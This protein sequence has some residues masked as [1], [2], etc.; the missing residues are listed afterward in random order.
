MY[1]QD[2]VYNE[3]PK[4]R[5]QLLVE[6]ILEL[7]NKIT[8]IESGSGSSSGNSSHGNSSPP[9]LIG[10]PSPAGAVYHIPAPRR[11]S[12]TGNSPRGIN[13]IWNPAPAPVNPAYLHEL[14]SRLRDSLIETFLQNRDRCCL[15]LHVG[16]FIAALSIPPNDHRALHPALVQAVLLIG[17]YFSRS[18]SMT[19][20]EVRFLAQARHDLTLSVT[21]ADRLHDFVRASNLVAFYYFCK[22]NYTEAYQQVSASSN[23]AMSCGLH[24]IHSSVWRPGSGMDDGDQQFL[25]HPVDNTVCFDKVMS[26]VVG[27]PSHLA[28]GPLADPAFRVTTPWPRLIQDY[29]TAAVS[30]QECHSVESLY[31]T[32]L[33]H[34]MA[35]PETLTSLRVQG[36]CLLHYAYHLSHV[37]N[38]VPQDV[39]LLHTAIQYY[40]ARLPGIR[41]AGEMGE[42]PATLGVSPVNQRLV[43]IRTLPLVA[44]LVL[45]QHGG[46]SEARR[47]CGIA[48]QGIVAIIAELAD[49]DYSGLFVG[50]GHIW[51][52][53]C[54]IMINISR[55]AI[56]G[57]REQ[58]NRNLAVV[59]RALKK[60]SIVYPLLG[61]QVQQLELMHAGAA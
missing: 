34:P 41:N 39:H 5:A 7:E 51:N 32:R 19:D 18:P 37:V 4:S 8:Q 46:D 23:M 9:R 17:S 11:T 16:R 61:F 3:P 58:V 45:F 27:R 2:C 14:P 56:A 48:S 35:R 54:Q 55:A 13:W 15:D 10:R 24:Q 53:T 59:M 49:D 22:G 29:E 57:T 50:L 52:L 26:M 12:P 40:Q 28:N 47:Q 25:N 20:Y 21:N 31:N 33:V 60:L 44:T 1:R 30:D 6:R 42:I 36:L 43:L 38:P